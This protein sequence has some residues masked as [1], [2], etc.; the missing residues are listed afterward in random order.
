MVAG[1]VIGRPSVTGH[2]ADPPA[3]PPA[4]AV[5][6][7]GRDEAELAMLGR[8]VDA[9]ED[10]VLVLDARTLAVVR[11]NRAAG[12]RPGPGPS[13]DLEGT[14]PACLVD[15]DEDALRGMIGPL[16][17]GEADAVRLETRRRRWDGSVHP[18]EV[19]LSAVPGY[20]DPLIAL[21]ATDISARRATEAEL[22]RRERDNRRL[23]EEQGALRRVATAVARGEDPAILFELVCS[24][25]RG[26]LRADSARLVRFSGSGPAAVVGRSGALDPGAPVCPLAEAVRTTGDAA[27]D[28]SPARLAVPVRGE[29]GLWGAL[30]VGGHAEP[31][32]PGACH[33][34]SRFSELVGIA[35][36]NAEA[37]TRLDALAGT[38]HLT[39][40]ANHR[41][42]HEQLARACAAAAGGPL[43]LVVLDIDNFARINVA[44]GH[45]AGDAALTEVAR[46]LRA[47][48]GPEASLA[49]IG[50][51]EFAWIIPGADGESG[52]VAAEAVRAAIAGEPLPAVGGVTVSVGAC[53]LARA[54]GAEELFRLAAGALYW[55]KLQGRDAACLYSPDVVEALSADEQAER[56]ARA[57]AVQSI[58]VLARAVDAKDPS[59]RRHSER[60]AAVARA[61]AVELGWSR[62]EA[63]D[64]HG[65]GLV[66][67]VGKIAVPDAILFKPDRLTEEEFARVRAHAA[68]GADMVDD[69]LAPRQVAWVRGH[70]ERWDGAGY[71]DALAGPAI[72]EGARILTLADSWDVMT[73]TRPYGATRALDDALTEC[74][75]CSGRQF[76]PPAV[77]ALERLVAEGRLPGTSGGQDERRP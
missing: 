41:T 3:S 6:M 36:A 59:T 40:F 50:G 52:L 60:V 14:P 31:D 44:G 69:V 34:L 28:R 27:L 11:A 18:V 1:P 39:G 21:V 22:R 20:A 35:V 55:A 15:L 30:C 71:P 54:S 43:A 45:G 62:Q 17:C 70:H 48:A 38:D 66:H 64:L 47:V 46:R 72:P 23:A 42:F 74:H 9:S 76:W 37:R 77:R 65:A 75:R 56:L 4:P 33:R 13:G 26:L 16:L 51:D 19:R 63:D 57:Q 73:S 12:V 32:E 25:A 58:R 53:D 67:D 61:V 49:R 29:G 8:L 24:E 2:L 7:P 10:L 5:R 68:L